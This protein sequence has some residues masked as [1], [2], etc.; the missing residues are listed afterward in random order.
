MSNLSIKINLSKIPG[1]IFTKLTGK[2]G[3][4][5]DC[6]VI[7]VEDC[8]LFVGEKGVYLDLSAYEFREQKYADSHMVKQSFSKETIE[9]IKQ[10]ALIV[11]P[12]LK[13]NDLQEVV[14]KANPIIGG[15]KPFQ[16]TEMQPTQVSDFEP[17]PDDLPF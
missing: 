7:P 5:K 3:Q 16:K 17:Q 15:I 1:T 6:I 11:N 12:D 10:L 13:E 2:S 14:N 4:K 9:E 8:H